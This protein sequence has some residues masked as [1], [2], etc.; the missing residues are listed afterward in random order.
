MRN[1]KLFII[2]GILLS[3]TLLIAIG[4]AV[5]SIRRVD[6]YCFNSDNE[7]LK[8]QVLKNKDKLIGKSIFTLNENKLIAEIE[9][10]VGGI[11]IVNVERLF[12][13]RVSVNF[14]ELF[15]YFEIPYGGKYYVCAVDGRVLHKLDESYGKGII[16]LLM[17]LGRDLE[18]GG[19]VLDN[20]RFECLQ[21]MISMLERLDFRETEAT[22]IIKTIDLDYSDSS[23]YVTTHTGVV[24]KLLHNKFTRDGNAGEKLRKALSLYQQRPDYRSHGMIIVTAS[25]VFSYSEDSD[26][27]TG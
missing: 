22:A 5:F 11:K 27:I 21:D 12:P 19:S 2:F 15:P 3:L 23:I 1:K 17:P 16:R 8:T 4:S 7:E 9:S 26:Y 20:T 18:V 6:A 10:E 14:I 24:I 25:D 13:N